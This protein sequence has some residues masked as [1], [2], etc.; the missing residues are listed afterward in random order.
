[1]L[2]Y[3][4]CSSVLLATAVVNVLDSPNQTHSVRAVLDSASQACFITTSLKSRLLLQC[5]TVNMSLQGISRKATPI[6]EV[7]I[8][9]L[10]SRTSS[11]NKQLKC[12][13]LEQIS[14]P[15]PRHFIN[16]EKWNLSPYT[17]LADK[18][19]NIPSGIDLLI[20]ANIFFELLQQDK[21]DL[22]PAKPTLQ[23]SK[24]GWIVA[25]NYTT[26]SSSVDI[27]ATVNSFSKVGGV[28]ESPTKAPEEDQKVGGDRVIKSSLVSSHNFSGT[29]SSYCEAHLMTSMETISSCSQQS[30][31]V[32]EAKN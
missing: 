30:Q 14:E 5:E 27:C 17:P 1:M 24:L 11:Y 29:E 25:G 16:I 26:E 6:S 28:I 7:V 8:V 31:A 13:V 18:K 15:L 10:R 20:G 12:A 23:N 3:N 19:F 4:E 32:F 2:A 9:D 22:G 21:V